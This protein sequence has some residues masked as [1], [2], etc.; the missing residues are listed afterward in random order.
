M[1]YQRLRVDGIRD[2][3]RCRRTVRSVES[4][5]QT[6]LECLLHAEIRIQTTWIVAGGEDKTSVRDTV[7]T[8]AAFHHK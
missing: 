7:L 4:K 6:L 1:M 3:F 8:R 5:T 2:G